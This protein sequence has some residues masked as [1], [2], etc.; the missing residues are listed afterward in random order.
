MK[1]RRPGFP[2]TYN[3]AMPALLD[4]SPAT[5]RRFERLAADLGRIFGPRLVGVIATS[6][7]QAVAFADSVASGDLEAASAL[8]ETWHKDELDTPLLLT[9]AEFRR[10]LDAF[11]VEYHTMMSR[12]AVIAGR[13][14]FQDLA[15]PLDHLRRACE[16]QAKGHLIHLRQGWLEAAGHEE[17]LADL[18]ARSAPPLAALLANV[19]RLHGADGGEHGGN[20]LAGARLAGLPDALIRE[21]LA[22]EDA[23]ERS[24]ELVRHLPAYVEASE[25]LWSFVDRWRSP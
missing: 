4:L 8:V 11:P 2:A 20:A 13:P 1:P 10:S 7:T 19:A 12:H 24:G 16:V 3:D 15:V 22:L 17:A 5:R 14:P 25:Q 21:V 23:P 18:V 6:G 9:A